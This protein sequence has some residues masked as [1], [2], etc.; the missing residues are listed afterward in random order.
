[1]SFRVFLVVQG[2]IDLAAHSIAE[3]GLGPAPSLR[4]HFLILRD[5]GLLDHALAEQLAAAVRVRNLIGLA[6]A[7]IDPTKRHAAAV[8]IAGLVDP[9]CAAILAQADRG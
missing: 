3:R 6:Y 2:A 8:E 1:M 7:L 4:D 9:F 5:Q